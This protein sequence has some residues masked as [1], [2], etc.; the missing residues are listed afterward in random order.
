MCS[1]T[2][3][4]G[5]R[6]FVARSAIAAQLVGLSA[7]VA[8][9]APDEE[10][11]DTQSAVSI[12]GPTVRVTIDRPNFFPE[13]IAI[14][15]DKVYVGSPVTG[16]VVVK[17]LSKPGTAASTFIPDPPGQ[18]GA[19]GLLI[20]KPAGLLWMCIADFALTTPSALRSFSL[21]TG[22]LV[23]EYLL[24]G[25]AN[26]FCNDIA[27][28]PSGNLY[29]T[30]S[31]G[32]RVMRL[33]PGAGSL[34][35]WSADP[36]L[37]S[38]PPPGLPPTL[39]GVG[40]NG[41]VFDDRSILVNKFN[42]AQLFRIPITSTAAAGPAQ[43]IIVQPALRFT[44]GMKRVVP[45]LVLVIEPPNQLSAILVRGNQGTKFVLNS[46]L[47]NPTTVDIRPSAGEAYVVESQIDHFL[48]IDPAPP[49]MPFKVQR[50]A[51]TP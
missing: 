42:T 49:E 35:I 40:I 31:L 9:Q 32:G 19:V 2:S 45:G 44:D 18:F 7:C 23:R 8:S 4:Q 3:K 30:E 16:E 27:R 29:I 37:S 21:A 20:D 10:L 12:S 46:A 6:A 5:Y 41:I 24:P 17:D 14:D 38:P 22:A 39:A 51:V 25:G 26:N 1:S 15:G 34:E 50:F 43:E 11:A 36:R 47:D 28:D 33:R 13:G 48:G